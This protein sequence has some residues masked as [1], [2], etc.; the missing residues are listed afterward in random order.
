MDRIRIT[1]PDKPVNGNIRI[2]GS[3]SI[4]NRVLIIRALCDEAF[5]MENLSDST[6]TERL[7]SILTDRPEV[8]DAH[9]AGTTFRFLTAFLSFREGTQILTGS[10]RMKERPVGPLVESL[11]AI[12]ARIEYIE[13]EGYPP[14][15]ILSPGAQETDKVTIRSDISSQF[16]SALALV[17]PTLP[18]GLRIELSGD[19]VST[20]Y[21]QMTLNIMRQFGVETSF[22]DNVI[23]IPPQ[24]YNPRPYFVESDWSSASY[25]FAIAVLLPGSRITLDAYFE[26]SVQ[27]DSAL[28]EMGK[29][30]GLTTAFEDRQLVIESKAHNPEIFTYDFINQP[31]LAQTFAVLTGA[32]GTGASCSG[33]QTLRIKET[34]RIAALKNELAKVHVS[35][36]ENRP[37]RID[38]SGKA[39]FDDIPVFDTYKDHRMAMSLAPLSILHPIDINQPGVVAKSYPGF[40]RDLEKLGFDLKRMI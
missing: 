1:G 23:H 11:K 18:K 30:F 20:S 17:A 13:K 24:S 25:Y 27:G 5:P 31:D 14:L 29:H 40:W 28:T 39:T 3:K 12:G 35:V 38:I 36:V 9:H 32:L 19:M 34:D 4:S 22:K 37:A 21:L 7:L 15:K 10:S 6:D 33:L 2:G 26:D 8:C 16:I